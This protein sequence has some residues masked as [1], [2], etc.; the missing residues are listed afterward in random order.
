MCF[1]PINLYW[2]RLPK[3]PFLPKVPRIT[4]EISLAGRYLVLVPFSD[5]ISVSQ[6]IKSNDE[7]SRLKRLVQ[8][9]KPKN[10]GVIVRTVA[11]G[12]MVADLDADLQN[13]V[14]KWYNVAAKLEQAKHPKSFRAKSIEHLQFFV[15]C[16]T[17][18]F[19]NIHVNDQVH[20]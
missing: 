9:I 3:S 6:K 12:K 19:N 8:S 2:F 20:I 18:D 13:L 11:E 14:A 4:S 16:L 1:P 15:I 10:F 17:E 5:R 7:K